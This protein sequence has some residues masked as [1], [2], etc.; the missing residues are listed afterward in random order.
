MCVEA[1][2]KMLGLRKFQVLP[3]IHLAT[4]HKTR[5]MHLL[6]FPQNKTGC[7]INFCSKRRIRD[8]LLRNHAG[9]YC[10]VRP[11]FRGNV[12]MSFETPPPVKLRATDLSELGE[13]LLQNHLLFSLFSPPP[14][15]APQPRNAQEELCSS[16][17]VLY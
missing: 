15:P 4:D 11:S 9:A 3:F 8:V 13:V 16:I 1:L 10:P 5:E 2:C 6:C 12:V 7:Y 17:S 14:P